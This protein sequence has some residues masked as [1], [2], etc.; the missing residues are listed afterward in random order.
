MFIVH[1][2][3][4]NIVHYKQMSIVHL[5][6][7]TQKQH[8][9][10]FLYCW[11]VLQQTYLVSLSIRII[12]WSRINCTWHGY[13]W[14]QVWLENRTCFPYYIHKKII[15]NK[16]NAIQKYSCFSIFQQNIDLTCKWHKNYVTYYSKLLT[17]I[18][19]FPP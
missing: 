16:T 9:I 11:K 3:H 14:V 15:Q 4:I 13:I 12:L 17:N 6:F 1:N 19:W 10:H 2:S 18:G 7:C 8:Q 5:A